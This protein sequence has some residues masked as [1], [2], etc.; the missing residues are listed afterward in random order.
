MTVPT[1][2][3][4]A[5]LLLSLAP[6]ATIAAEGATCTPKGFKLS[7]PVGD[8]NGPG[9]YTY[10]TDAVYKPG[11]FDITEFEVAQS[12][13]QVEFRVSVRARIEDPWDSAAWG[14]NGFSV[15][16]VFIHIDTDHKAGSG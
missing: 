8:D 16:M 7:D 1:R 14:G 11:S 13:D 6:A 12:G 3:L 4:L 2:L 10:P 5:A 9:N 15:Q